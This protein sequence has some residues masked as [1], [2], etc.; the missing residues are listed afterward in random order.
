MLVRRKEAKKKLEAQQQRLE[1]IHAQS[2]RVEIGDPQ[3]RDK[4]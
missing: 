3:D 2:G 1:G 4:Q